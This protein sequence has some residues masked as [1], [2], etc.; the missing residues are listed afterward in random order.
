MHTTTHWR[1]TAARAFMIFLCI[2]L[3]PAMSV[4]QVNKAPLIS[5]TP[6]ATVRVSSAYWFSPDARDP[7]NQPQPLRFSIANKPAW[8]AFSTT[9]GRLTGTPTTAGSW[10]NIRISVTD[11]VASAALPA[12]QITASTSGSSTGNR[13]PVISGTPA[14]SITVGSAYTFRPTASDP[15][16]NTLGFSIQNRPGW[17]S[18]N[19]STGQLSGTPTSANVGT[20][21]NIVIS[22]SDG[23]ASA[24]LPAFA[25]T[26]RAA[27]S[28][29]SPPVISGTPPT[30]AR[31]GTAYSFT[32]TAS[33]PNGNALTF[34]VQNRPA[35]ATFSTTTGRL[36][37]TPAAANVGTYSN[38][39]I[40]V[41]DGQAS[42][43]LNPFAI[44]VS[45]AP[46]NGS[47]TL[48]WTAPT[49]NTDGSALT[50]LAGYRIFY[51]TSSG[52]MTQMIQVG[53]GGITSYV[54]SNLSPATY[55][56]TVRAYNSGGAESSASNTASKTIQ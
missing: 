14:T 24:S 20:Y 51:G 41:S 54:V 17:A 30:S 4:A 36:S 8:A 9:T 19:T 22:V 2:A 50:N 48:R 1:A 13:A 6:P 27:T 39:V 37:G 43:S 15:D 11:G 3:A 7:D 53:N 35:W 55:Y 18:F 32:P 42:A 40:G 45:D 33:D 5:G 34:S 29:N 10:S 38:I 56:F 44:T 31:T 26:V 52:S 28:G 47:A 16:G 12:F 49:R 25:I 21:S 46:A 23:T